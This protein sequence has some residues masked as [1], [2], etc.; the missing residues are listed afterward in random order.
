M[1]LVGRKNANEN[2]ATTK[3]GNVEVFIHRVRTRDMNNRLAVGGVLAFGIVLVVLTVA[4]HTTWRY[5]NA[6]VV[7]IQ[8]DAAPRFTE[9]SGE[10]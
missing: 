6:W 2:Y 10:I 5:A 9:G 4:S 3:H 7:T 1:G 8:E